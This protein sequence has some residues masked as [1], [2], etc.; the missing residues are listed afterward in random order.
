MGG[1]VD[2]P[3]RRGLI[4]RTRISNGWATPR[5]FKQWGSPAG[6]GRTLKEGIVGRTE[7]TKD[8]PRAS[9]IG[10]GRFFPKTNPGFIVTGTA[11]RSGGRQSFNFTGTRS[12]ALTVDYVGVLWMLQT[13]LRR[14]RAARIVDVRPQRLEG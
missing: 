5:T 4:S 10:H 1:G 6:G 8:V 2:Y 3:A 9:A 11:G 14:A 13:R 7:G 12:T